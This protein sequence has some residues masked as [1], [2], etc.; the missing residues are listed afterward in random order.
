MAR[1]IAKFWQPIDCDRWGGGPPGPVCE[2]NTFLELLAR[3]FRALNEDCMV[4]G[5]YQRLHR[6]NSAC[7]PGG[8]YE[9]LTG[10]GSSSLDR[11]SVPVERGE[12]RVHVAEPEGAL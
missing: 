7:C 10:E 4:G 1:C 3:G 6:Y 8:I 11:C 5:W 12:R 2:L 9:E